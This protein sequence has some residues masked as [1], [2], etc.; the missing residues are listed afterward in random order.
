ML[1]ATKVDDL[2]GM[3]ERMPD[4]HFLE[5]KTALHRACEEV[6]LLQDIKQAT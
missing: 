2:A 4:S 6:P 3:Q 5:G 1:Q